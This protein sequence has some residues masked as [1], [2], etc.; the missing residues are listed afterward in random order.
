MFYLYILQ[1]LKDRRTYVGH[2]ADIK[3]RL[4]EHN[5]GRVPATKNRQPLKILKFEIHATLNEAKKRELYWKS[6]AGRRKLKEL[7]KIEILR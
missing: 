5:S 7:F 4:C 1:S 6:G 2:T 3:R